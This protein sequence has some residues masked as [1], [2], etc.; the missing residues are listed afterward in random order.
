MHRTRTFTQPGSQRGQ[1]L[2]E[3]VVVAVF[4]LVPLFL[5]MPVV[6]KL[7]SQK[8]DVEVAARYAAWERTVWHQDGDPDHLDGYGGPVASKSDA[9]VAREIDT[10]IFAQDTQPIVSE[11][12]SDSYELDPFS[13]RQN[14]DLA[15]LI[16]ANGD[17]G[18]DNAYARQSANQTEPDGIVS[19]GLS[20]FLSAVGSLTNFELNTRGLYDAEV[21]VDVIDLTDV[22]GLGIP[23]DDLTLSGNNALLAE[24]WAAGGTDHAAYRISGLL[25]QTLFDNPVVGTVQDLAGELPWIT[26]EL[27]SDCLDFGRVD[28]EPVPGHRLSPIDTDVRGDG[29]VTCDL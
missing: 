9:A 25:P 20:S 27:D 2:T 3:F 21:A 4:I 7:I 19:Q 23:M 5:I 18:G 14:G 8:Q 22:F 17:G 28:L 6:A 16:A 11:D 13:R 15:P 12:V 26:S 10:R 29:A 1:A 24:S